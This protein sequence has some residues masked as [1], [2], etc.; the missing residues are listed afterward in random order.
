M[1]RKELEKAAKAAGEKTDFICP[2]CKAEI[3]Y[4][5]GKNIACSKCNVVMADKK[6]FEAAEKKPIKDGQVTTK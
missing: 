5:T 2:R 6:A 3:K 4:F 1:N